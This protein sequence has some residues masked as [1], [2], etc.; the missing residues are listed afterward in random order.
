MAIK[1]EITIR[2]LS[3]I[4][5]KTDLLLSSRHFHLKIPSEEVIMCDATDFHSNQIQ[6]KTKDGNEDADPF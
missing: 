3:T 6:N 5:Q 1:R 2:L 4:M